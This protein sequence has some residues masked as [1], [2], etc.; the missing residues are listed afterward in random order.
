MIYETVIDAS[1]TSLAGIALLG[2]VLIT[3]DANTPSRPVVVEGGTGANVSAVSSFTVANGATFNPG[4]LLDVTAGSSFFIDGGTLIINSTLGISALNTFTFLPAGGEIVVEPGINVNLN[5]PVSGWNANSVVDFPES[6]SVTATFNGTNTVLTAT[7]DSILDIGQSLTI[8]GNIFGLA[9]NASTT[10][11]KPDGSGGILVCFLEGTQIKTAGGE[12]PVENIRVHDRVVAIVNG[13]AQLR[14]VVWVGRKAVDL[15]TSVDT[16]DLAPIRIKRDAIADGVPKRDLLVT[17]DHCLIFDGYLMPARALVNGRSIVKDTSMLRFT[18]F[19]IETATHSILLAEGALAESYLDTGNRDSFL[20]RGVRIASPAAPKTWAN[21]AAASLAIDPAIVGPVWDRLDARAT[22]RGY[23]PR[24]QP[25][26]TT[27]PKLTLRCEDGRVL[28]PLR[29][30]G[31]RFFFRLPA[32]AKG[33]TVASRSARPCDVQGAFVDDRRVLGVR[34]GEIGIWRGHTRSAYTC[35]LTAEPIAGWME[36]E[37]PDSRWTNG[38][39]QLSLEVASSGE[40]T[41]IE[42]QIVAAGPYRQQFEDGISEAA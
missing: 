16:D 33:F 4:S 40:L 5:A 32:G 37:A 34:V 25:S 17:G 18:V 36:L 12:V 42:I 41:L 35:H 30:D 11:S 10:F 23:A 24:P 19:H 7:G 21:D 29:Q 26:L 39:G 8:G 15:S 2:N 27:N 22:D 38:C 20:S 28:Q 9:T 13:A 3:Q 6:T 1:T 31:N 14:R